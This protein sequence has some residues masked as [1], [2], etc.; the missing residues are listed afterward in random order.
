MTEIAYERLLEER[1]DINAPAS[2]VWEL[3]RDVRR[4]AEWSPQVESTRLADGRTEVESG[5]AFTNHNR[6]GELT[7]TT[8]GT[9]V[10]FEPNREI[11]FR[12]EENWVVW[13]FRIEGTGRDTVTLVQRREAPDGISDYSLD[14]TEKYMG[15]QIEFTEV[16]R[17][18]MRQT[19]A[20]IAAAAQS[21]ACRRPMPAGL[22]AITDPT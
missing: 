22:T 2:V 17:A 9:V 10:R 7:W 12:I 1:V 3:I 5:V 13:S 8:H 14:L 21:A 18:G 19:L 6:H 4:L 15:G 20:G 11:A 16:M